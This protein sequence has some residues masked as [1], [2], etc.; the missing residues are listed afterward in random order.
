MR[1]ILKRS[2]CLLLLAFFA[3]A[4]QGRGAEPESGVRLSALIDELLAHNPQLKQ[5]QSSWR[6]AAIAI[7]QAGAWMD[8]MLGVSIMNLPLR[9]FDLDQEPMTGKQV[10]IVKNVP[11]PGITG[12]REDG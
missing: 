6:A 1:L 4:A 8:P 3:F 7:P 9:T 2:C 5:Y 10:S 12:L 11:F